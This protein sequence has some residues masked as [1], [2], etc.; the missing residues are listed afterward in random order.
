MFLD[1]NLRGFGVSLL[2]SSAFLDGTNFSYVE[3]DFKAEQITC[4][5]SAKVVIFVAECGQAISLSLVLENSD[6]GM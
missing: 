4:K 3:C 5:L 1:D 6:A 2:G